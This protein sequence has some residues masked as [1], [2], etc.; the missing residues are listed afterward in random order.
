MKDIDKKKKR[1]RIKIK[2]KID[3][4]GNMTK[5][6][7]YNNKQYRLEEYFETPKNELKIQINEL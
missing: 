5:V 2:Y 1:N 7:G 3:K 6:F 4:K